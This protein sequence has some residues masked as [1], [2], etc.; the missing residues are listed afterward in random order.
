MQL[1]ALKMFLDNLLN[2]IARAPAT[3]VLALVVPMVALFACAVKFQGLSALPRIIYWGLIL[4]GAAVI[5]LYFATS[6]MYALSL[7]FWDHW[8]PTIASIS[9]YFWSGN[10]VYP[11]P[12]S[13]EVYLTH[14]GPYLYIFNGAIEA[15]LRPSI[16]SAKLGGVLFGCGSVLAVFF[17]VWRYCAAS[18]A[19]L[20]TSLFVAM[21]LHFSHFSFWN[22][23]EP[24]LVFFVSGA[25]LAMTRPSWWSA[26]IV[27]IAA[28]VCLNLKIH[29][30]LYFIPLLA[31]TRRPMSVRHIALAIA[32]LCVVWMAPF[33]LFRNISFPN[34]CV[35]LKMG[36]THGFDP[37]IYA[38][39]L[40]WCFLLAMP[41]GL[42]TILAYIQDP[43]RVKHAF[44]KNKMAVFLIML[45]FIFMLIPASKVGS[46]AHHYMP[47]LPIVFLV[48]TYLH[49]DGLVI[50]FNHSKSTLLVYAC[51]I[52][53]TVCLFVFAGFKLRD[54]KWRLQS[55]S[56]FL[57]VLASE[58][59]EVLDKYG[60][61]HVVCMG[62]AGGP[63][64]GGQYEF[65][66]LRPLLVFKGMP[67][68][69]DPAVLMDRKKAGGTIPP[70]DA[71]GKSLGTM[72]V[73]WMIPKGE[74][75]FTLRTWYP[76]G[77]DLYGEQFRQ[78]FSSLWGV[79]SQIP[80]FNLYTINSKND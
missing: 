46:G 55:N 52:S 17:L 3:W 26:I 42:I 12:N 37:W 5:V 28:G 73:M 32:A 22:R 2:G 9:W 30:I 77:D 40:R 74:E 8:E 43:D 39:I 58:I 72:P 76:P 41:V 33:C 25:C 78:D 69:L 63:Q 36:A 18:I 65:T 61:T 7:G 27:G 47:F 29:S 51:L 66:Y 34:Y 13:S 20:A 50:H 75:P 16:F 62:Q 80:H 11:D 10:D 19:L 70:A 64:G 35:A 44:D 38:G 60:G 59:Q 53:W 67:I 68:G 45:A 6:G 48:V 21:Q 79:S 23:P 54:M 56:H 31:Y 4:M 1:H 57:G 14:F 71:I 15:L 49:R 24:F